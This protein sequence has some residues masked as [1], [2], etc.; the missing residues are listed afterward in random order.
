[1]LSMNLVNDMQMFYVVFLLLLLLFYKF[2]I[3]LKMKLNNQSKNIIGFLRMKSKVLTYFFRL[4]SCYFSL[5]CLSFSHNIC[6]H[7]VAQLCRTFRDPMDC[8]PPGS[9]VQ[10]IFQ[11]RILK[12]VAISYSRASSWSRDWTSISHLSCSGRWILYHCATWEAL[13][14]WFQFIIFTLAVL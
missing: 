1:M 8:K 4:T 12:W 14:T 3:I 9:S 13:N 5:W 10:G 11:A 7:S 6:V 2:E